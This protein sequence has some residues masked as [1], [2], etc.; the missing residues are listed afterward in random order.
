MNGNKLPDA[1]IAATSESH[2]IPLITADTG[3]KKAELSN[4]I[5]YDIV[6]GS[7]KHGKV[8]LKKLNNF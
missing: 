2:D 7:V 1:I 3:I 5:F 4:T 8:M 6:K